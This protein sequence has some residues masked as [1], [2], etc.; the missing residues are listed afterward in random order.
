MKCFT[1][2]ESVE[3][4]IKLYSDPVQGVYVGLGAPVKGRF[5]VSPAVHDKFH[6]TMAELEKYAFNTPR[7]VDALTAG[8][9]LE[10]G[11]LSM[12]SGDIDR[13]EIGNVFTTAN[14]ASPARQALVLVDTAPG[15]GGRL[16]YSARAYTEEVSGAGMRAEVKKK[17]LAFPP[18]GI[19]VL[20]E[21]GGAKLLRMLPGSGFALERDGDLADVPNRFT[22]NWQG[23][24]LRMTDYKALSKLMRQ[25]SV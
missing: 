18:P 11:W 23:S 17:Y 9:I 15:E 25:H 16:Y 2:H 22:I 4:G 3:R 20:A 14:S 19:E 5:P 8:D 12:T 24:Q 21:S 13:T 1:V 10:Q 6:E 7:Y